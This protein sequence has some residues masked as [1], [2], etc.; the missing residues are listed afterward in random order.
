VGRIADFASAPSG[1]TRLARAIPYSRCQTAQSSSF[2]HAFLRPG[3][4]P[5]GLQG[6]LSTTRR[7]DE[8]SRTIRSIASTRRQYISTIRSQII[9]IDMA[10]CRLDPSALEPTEG[11][12]TGATGLRLATGKAERL[13]WLTPMRPAPPSP[14]NASASPASAQTVAPPFRAGHGVRAAPSAP[15]NGSP[16]RR[17]KRVHATSAELRC[18]VSPV[19]S[20]GSRPRS[21]LRLCARTANTVGMGRSAA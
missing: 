3:W 10:S 9:V 21:L 16:T 19:L 6:H 4:S 2:P 17:R 15:S 1:P 14:P 5:P 7:P 8:R 11:A 18:T 12:P 20:A 13:N